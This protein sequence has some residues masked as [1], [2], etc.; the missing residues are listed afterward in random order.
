MT[1]TQ[2][3][4]ERQT[5]VKRLTTG[6]NELDELLLGGIETSAITEIYG[7]YTSGKT[8]ISH[9][10]AVLAQQPLEQKGYDSKVIYMD[11][12]N[13]FGPERINKICNARELDP[14]KTNDNI[15]VVKVYN[16]AHQ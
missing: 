13:T 2:F 5:K 8:Q 7:E 14:K 9:T 12:E 15:I 10:S 6:S 1:C 11:M 4:E 3:H 16:V